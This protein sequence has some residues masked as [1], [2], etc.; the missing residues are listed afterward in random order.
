[1][2]KTA[3]SLFITAALLVAVAAPAAAQKQAPAAD[4]DHV[5]A[6]IEEAKT[7]LAQG[8]QT[9]SPAQA[10]TTTGP[11]VDLTADQAVARALERNVTLSQQRLT[12]QTFDYSLAATYAFYRPNLNSTVSTQSADDACPADHRRRRQDQQRH[13]RL[14]RRH[15]A[16]YALAGWQLPGQLDEQPHRVEPEQQ[17]FQSGLL[18]RFPGHLRPADSGQPQD[19]TRRARTS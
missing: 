8:G 19:S 10:A 2:S 13:G 3:S 17:H 7:R 16:E 1:M 4:S 5:K 15:R 6:L 9:P 11:R 12:P 14:E 18:G